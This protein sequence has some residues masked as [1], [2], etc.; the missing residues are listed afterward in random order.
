MLPVEARR[1]V[2]LRVRPRDGAVR[3]GA[4]VGEPVE[5]R[6]IARRIAPVREQQQQIAS[7]RIVRLLGGTGCGLTRFRC[8]SQRRAQ[9]SRERVEHGLAI[10][11]V[12]ALGLQIRQPIDQCVR[13]LRR[14]RRPQQ[15]LTL[16]LRERPQDH[17]VP[18]PGFRLQCPAEREGR[19]VTVEG[20]SPRGLIQGPAQRRALRL[21][22]ELRNAQHQCR[23][24][25][26]RAV[27]Q[28]EHPF[29][30][31]CDVR[32]GA[33]DEHDVVVIEIRVIAP[34]R[35]ALHPPRAEYAVQ[36]ARGFL[37]D[38]AA[39]ERP[40]RFHAVDET[41]LRLEQKAL[42]DHSVVV[43]VDGR[44]RMGEIGLDRLPARD[45]DRARGAHP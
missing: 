7:R 27:P 45:C 31:P 8:D 33:V 36:N 13:R 42:R 38:E 44:T 19:H 25:E 22:L 37:I 15:Q 29:L 40:A 10:H 17:E 18:Q 21:A 6:E 5:Q 11:L 35:A 28:R 14:D 12:A 30:L 23:V 4:A 26:L 34:A 39:V 3:A 16:V 32:P 9:Q 1:D 43:E 41:R 20:E 24:R 2:P